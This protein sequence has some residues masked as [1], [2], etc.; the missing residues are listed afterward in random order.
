MRNYKILLTAVVTASVMIQSAVFAGGAKPPTQDELDKMQAALPAKAT[1]KPLKAR[2]ILIFDRCEGFVHNCIPLASKTFEMMG[3]KTGAYQSVISSDMSYF[4]AAGLAEFD[5]VLFN[6]TTKLSF[7]NPAHRKA[8]MDF[9]KSG[10]GIIGIHAASDNFYSWPEAADMI[11]GQFN[12]HPWR[13]NG[14]WAVKLDE[15]THPVNKGFGGKNFMINDEIYQM[16][17]AYSRKTHRV[18]LSLDMTQDVNKRVTG[19]KRSDNDFAIAWIKKYGSGRVFYSSLGH[20][21]AIYWNPAVLQHY[22]DGIQYAL[23]DLK[24][25]DTP[26]A[27]LKQK[28]NYEKVLSYEFGSDKTAIGEITKSINGASPAELAEIEA[29]LIK[30]LN[31]P[32]ATKACR[33]FVCRMLR[34][35]G[36]EASVPALAG[37]LTD[38][39]LS[40]MARFALQGI[41]SPKVDT[42]LLDALKQVDPTLVPGMIGTLGQRRSA[43]AVP[44]LEE[45]LSSQDKTTATAAIVAMGHIGTV[46][47]A[48]A[49]SSAPQSI[50]KI[51]ITDALLTAAEHLTEAGTTTEAL[52]IYNKFYSNEQPAYIQVAALRGLVLTEKEK[53]LPLLV[54]VLKGDNAD[55]KKHAVA[56]IAELPAGIEI[57]KAIAK[58][59]P[60]LT[61]DIQVVL[62]GS[63]TDRAD[64]T[65]LAAISAA[66]K[67]DSTQAKIAALHALGVLNDSS[68]I[69]VLMDALADSD[70]T[71]AT[72]A[73]SL[74]RMNNPSIGTMLVS[75]LKN[76]DSSATRGMI[77]EVL[78]KRSEKAALPLFITALTDSDSKVSKAATKA[79][80]NLGGTAEITPILSIL[81]S[82]DNSTHRRNA[83]KAISMIAMHSKNSN[84][85]TKPVAEALKTASPAAATSLINILKRSGGSIALTA[86]QDELKAD[87]AD[88]RK[89]AIRALSDWKDT[90]P[91]DGLLQVAQGDSD[92]S[93][94]ILALRGYIGLVRKAGGDKGIEMSRKAL[95]TAV[96][97][98]DKKVVIS[99]LGTLANQ[100]ALA[101]VEPFL[102]QPEFQAEAEN[103]Y[104]AIA[105][106]ITATNPMAAN[107]AL[108]KVAAFQNQGLAENAKKELSKTESK[109]AFITD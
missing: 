97:P 85:I 93:A 108:Q 94:K 87:T 17:G 81:T 16:K 63:L 13:A 1:A 95:E 48:K 92:D 73:E 2:K 43:K 22:L 7:K 109:N 53:S 5:A 78:E 59:L 79:L 50:S 44:S 11:G 65:A 10:K 32:A 28:S 58:P 27:Q 66:A 104:S 70:K 4:D 72:A 62:I 55:L 25:D 40:H 89:E 102:T 21:R 101:L 52:A 49:I 96:R 98:E 31:N 91:A 3:K 30:V 29:E 37:L 12:G 61:P 76:S 60:T 35:C 103:A 86:L 100:D 23:G 54:D 24:A 41:D 42:A 18:L 57:T 33:Q 90:S 71:A 105:C 106:S 9:V 20:N 67:S 46:D 15:P 84:A 19:I 75:T 14:T 74:G 38:R 47:A 34:R 68:S 45:L 99:I 64:T 36:T 51:L 69:P 88:R 82:T 8:L 83:E 26:S 56:I 39:E 77:I 80:G 107:A 6:N